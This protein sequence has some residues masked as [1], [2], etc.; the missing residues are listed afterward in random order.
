MQL[1]VARVH[2]LPRLEDS[3]NRVE[4]LIQSERLAQLAIQ[5]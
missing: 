5:R 4:Q 3:L 1:A 2:F